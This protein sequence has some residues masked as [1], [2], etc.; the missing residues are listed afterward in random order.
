MQTTSFPFQN[1]RRARVADHLD[2]TATKLAGAALAASLALL[3]GCATAQTADTLDDCRA[4]EDNAERLACFDR[5]AGAEPPAPPRQPEAPA[6]VAEAPAAAAPPAQAET[7]APA[8][9]PRTAEPEAPSN[10]GLE[11]Q[12]GLDGPD[13]IVASV[14][15]G[16]Q[17]WGEYATED[18]RK[19]TV[20]EL[21]N[22]QVWVQ[23]GTQKFR[24]GGPDRKVEIRR[25]S[26]GSFLLSPEGYN[27]AVRVRRVK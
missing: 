7:P 27:R 21:D 9:P 11:R 8:A 15:G 22:G 25:A 20:F 17:G 23:V 19:K 4:I 14:V 13:R 16:F 26:F 3:S 18:G 24:Y 1:A 5:V 12:A 10:F 6:P 2:R